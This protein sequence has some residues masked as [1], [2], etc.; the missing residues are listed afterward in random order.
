[1]RKQHAVCGGLG[2]KGRLGEG[3]GGKGL[4][5]L[6]RHLGTPGWV[7]VAGQSWPGSL[8]LLERIKIYLTSL[9]NVF[10]SYRNDLVSQTISFLGV[11]STDHELGRFPLHMQTSV[12]LLVQ[13]CEMGIIKI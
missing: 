9:K 2:Q 11:I 4:E 6:Q 1:M 5:G 13:P 3:V 12:H 8:A 7:D 10:Q